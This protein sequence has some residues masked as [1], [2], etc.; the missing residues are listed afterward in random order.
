MSMTFPTFINICRHFAFLSEFLGSDVHLSIVYCTR[1]NILLEKEKEK[2]KV[3]KM[4]TKDTFFFSTLRIRIN[5]VRNE[6]FT[7]S[8]SISK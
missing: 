2:K 3:R 6:N 8:R 5:I 7:L 1:K 4:S